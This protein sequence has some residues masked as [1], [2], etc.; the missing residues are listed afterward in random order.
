[1][2]KKKVQIIDK[3]NALVDLLDTNLEDAAVEVMHTIVQLIKLCKEQ[4]RDGGEMKFELM[5]AE[6]K[7]RVDLL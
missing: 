4:E 6:I 1:M 2:S 5:G 7:I 3:N